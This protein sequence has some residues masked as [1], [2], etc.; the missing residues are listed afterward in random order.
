MRARQIAPVALVLGLTIVG[1]FG[2][3]LL[4]ER[5]ARREAEHRAEVAAAQI[6]GRVDEGNTLADGLRRFMVGVSGPG[7]TSKEFAANSARWLSPAGFPA[8]AWVEEVPASRRA[9]YQ[10]RIGHSIVTQTRRGGFA[11]A[12]PRRSYL[13]STLVSGVPPM[14]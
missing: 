3:R 12:G 1:F 9:T 5:D 13:P 11:P 14:T 7:A 2:A 8:A 4:G 6:H 10:A